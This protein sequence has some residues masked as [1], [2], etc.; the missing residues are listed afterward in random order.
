MEKSSEGNQIDLGEGREM[1]ANIGE[2]NMCA[3]NM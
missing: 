3:Q 1:I 2:M